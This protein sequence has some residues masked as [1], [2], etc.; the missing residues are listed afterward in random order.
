MLT[1]ELNW[2]FY[3]SGKVIDGLLIMRKIEVKTQLYQFVLK[4]LVLMVVNPLAGINPERNFRLISEFTKNTKRNIERKVTTHTFG[5]G[6][7][8][9]CVKNFNT[10][11]LNKTFSVI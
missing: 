4:Y 11:Y 1:S 5:G 8:K 2:S 6:E 7:N 9:E 3:V 10:A